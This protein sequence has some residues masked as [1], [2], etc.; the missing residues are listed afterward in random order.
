MK[1]SQLLEN[2]INRLSPTD[3]YLVDINP[4]KWLYSC[5]AINAEN[6]Q[7]NFGWSG[8]REG[9]EN[10]GLVTHS[11]R[12]FNDIPEGPKRQ[13]ARALWITWAALMAKEQGL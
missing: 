5:D 11:V 10:M 3:Q 1:L 6:A 8:I 7:H 9:L 13:Y 12:A 2:S 4:K